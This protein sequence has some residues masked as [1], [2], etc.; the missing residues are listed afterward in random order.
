MLRAVCASLLAL[1][2]LVLPGALPVWGQAAQ[3]VNGNR[4]HAG[5]TN[6]G[7]TAGTTN[8]Y[9]LTLNKPIP[10]YADGSCYLLELHAANTGPATLN[11]NGKGAKSILKFVAGVS[12]PLAA[13]DFGAGQ[14]V[15]VCYD[16]VNMQAQLGGGGGGG[17]PGDIGAVGSCTSADCFTAVSPDDSLTFKNATS[18]TVRLE[19]V[20]GALGNNVA[21]LKAETGNLCT[22][23]VVCTGYQ[24]LFNQL[25][26]DAQLKRSDNDFVAFPQKAVPVSADKLLVEDSAAAWA[27]KWIEIGSLPGGGAGGPGDVESVGTCASGPCFTSGN[28]SA[29]LF[30][31]AAAAPGAPIPGIGVVYYDPTNLNLSVKTSGNV[32][33]HGVQT[34]A[35]IANQFLTGIDA[36]GLVSSGV[37]L[38]PPA[39]RAA[40]ALTLANLGGS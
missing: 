11:V 31:Q 28:A 23:S 24:P 9:V 35:P 19:T 1:A 34:K 30:F 10:A 15:E 3:L 38:P 2:L 22:D 14:V 17:G 36:A 18:G 5:A 39:V 7:V 32:I 4:T 12:A 27:K 33:K 40:A 37:P 20:P 25:T 26:N 6:Y 8:T 29:A 16:G 13:D 21:R